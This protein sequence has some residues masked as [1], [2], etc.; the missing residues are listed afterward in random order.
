[1]AITLAQVRTE[2]AAAVAT[3]GRNFRYINGGG[4]CWY[5]KQTDEHVVTT[6]GRDGN[7]LGC[8]I[9]ACLIGVWRD[10]FHPE[11]PLVERSDVTQLHGHGIFADEVSKP[12]GKYPPA[13]TYLHVAQNA[14]DA[15]H[16][17]GEALDRAESYARS[18]T[19]EENTNA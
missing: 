19:G 16:T 10:M 5:V 18:I 14:Q 2:L 3:Q 1:M 17:W 11:I 13:L 4:G 12:F 9:S 6:L 7:P 8:T 15:G